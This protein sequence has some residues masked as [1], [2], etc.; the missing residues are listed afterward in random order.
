MTNYGYATISFLPTSGS[1]CGSSE[2]S[3]STDESYKE[4]DEADHTDVTV[5]AAPQGRVSV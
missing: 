5:R 4:T 2:A 3:E 1:D